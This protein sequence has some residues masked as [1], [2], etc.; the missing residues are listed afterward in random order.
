MPCTWTSTTVLGV[1]YDVLTV[2]NLGTGNELNYSLLMKNVDN[3][4]VSGLYDG[5]YC[6][7]FNGGTKLETKTA[8]SSIEYSAINKV[9]GVNTVATSQVNGAST[10]LTVTFNVDAPVPVGGSIKLCLPYSDEIY[11]ALSLTDQ[12]PTAMI[13]SLTPTVTASY[14]G[15]SFKFLTFIDDRSNFLRNSFQNYHD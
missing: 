14:S 10:S 5:V 9:D 3:G 1:V 13:S 2:T 12:S 6:E 7:S 11:Q 15:V 4:P 8:S